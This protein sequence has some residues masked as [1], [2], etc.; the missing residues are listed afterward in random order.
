M[1]DGGAPAVTVEEVQ[2]QAVG[3]RPRTSSPR[4]PLAL[5]AAVFLVVLIGGLV[6]D[7]LTRSSS[8]PTPDGT[9]GGPILPEV[10]LAPDHLWPIDPSVLSPIELGVDFAAQVLD[11]N[12]PS[13]GA[14]PAANQRGEFQTDGS[15][16]LRGPE[17]AIEDLSRVRIGQPGDDEELLDL[18]IGP[19][20]DGQIVT[21]VGPPWFMGVLI[22]P[23][24]PEG[25]R[26]TLL[27]IGDDVTGEVTVLLSDG[28]K[29]VV[30]AR[31]ELGVVDSTFVDLPMVRPDS[32]RSVLIRYVDENGNVIAANGGSGLVVSST[33]Q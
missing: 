27:R 17:I 16:R 25:T 4:H 23:L 33:G 22:A 1:F 14:F 26:I 31:I 8:E 13:G 21:E 30:S 28:T 19:I 15:P 9:L 11:W 20:E 29:V 6:I 3:T 10:Q 7:Q 32:V 5:T 24:D 2:Q 18:I 12:S